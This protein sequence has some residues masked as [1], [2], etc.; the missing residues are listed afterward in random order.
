MC[1]HCGSLGIIEIHR[2][3]NFN[4]QVCLLSVFAWSNEATLNQPLCLT[5]NTRCFTN[6]A[7]LA[8]RLVCSQTSQGFLITSRHIKGGGGGWFSLNTAE[9]LF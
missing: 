5:A 1:S 8:S 6:C 7:Q 4:M 2:C 9:A 3:K